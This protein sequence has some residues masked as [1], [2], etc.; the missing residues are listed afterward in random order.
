MIIKLSDHGKTLGPRVLGFKINQQVLS[1]I[2]VE[3]EI[4][5]DLSEINNLSTGFC[6]ELW[7][8]LYLKL[9]DDFSKK[10]KFKFDDQSDKEALIKIINRGISSSMNRSD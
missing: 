2:D 4:L 6:K 5:F 8:E 9:G 7:G 10:I 1:K 3:T